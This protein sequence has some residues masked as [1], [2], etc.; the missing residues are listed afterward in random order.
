MRAGIL[1]WRGWARRSQAHA[2]FGGDHLA[3]VCLVR[4]VHLL[5][6]VDGELDLDEVEEEVRR[7]QRPR[8]SN[9]R[10]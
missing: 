3:L 1:L 2:F 5:E 6:R 7:L 8:G 9:L 4:H 10:S